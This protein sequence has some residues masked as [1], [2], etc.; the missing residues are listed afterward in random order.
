[1]INALFGMSNW[2]IGAVN[3]YTY[4]NG[5]VT[6]DIK[7]GSMAM[8]GVLY[9]FQT[10]SEPRTRFSLGLNLTTSLISSTILS[11]GTYCIG[12]YVGKALLQNDTAL[13]NSRCII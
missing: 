10:F 3:G 5:G 13:H 11:G 12:N 9:F 7:Y 6:N 4:K 8:T 2:T 1:M